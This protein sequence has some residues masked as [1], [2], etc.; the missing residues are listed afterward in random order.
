MRSYTYHTNSLM[1]VI[2]FQLKYLAKQLNAY[3]K[4]AT[5]NSIVCCLST[6]LIRIV[7]PKEIF[8]YFGRLL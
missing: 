1:L 7:T 6:V 4:E 5:D 3:L 2:D 8:N